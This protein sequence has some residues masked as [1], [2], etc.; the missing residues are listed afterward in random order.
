[1]TAQRLLFSLA[2]VTLLSLQPACGG[3]ARDGDAWIEPQLRP[4]VAEFFE[5]AE[6]LGVL[7][8]GNLDQ[9]STTSLDP[10]LNGLCW[11]STGVVLVDRELDDDELRATVYHELA[12]CAALVLVHDRD[13]SGWMAKRMPAGVKR[14]QEFEK[15]WPYILRRSNEQRHTIQAA[16]D[17]GP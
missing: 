1:M 3:P 13:P 11:P 17:G 16:I 8:L 2:T 15:F 5:T 14:D 9:A 7:L 4:V 6:R 12:H 10:K